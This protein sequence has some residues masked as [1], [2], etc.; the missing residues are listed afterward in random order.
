MLLH[1]NG[2]IRT[3]CDCVRHTDVLRA[4]S[5]TC[6]YSPILRFN[7]SNRVADAE[8]QIGRQARSGSL[9]PVYD[10]IFTS[11]WAMIGS[12]NR[13]LLR[14]STREDSATVHCDWRQI[15]ENSGNK[16]LYLMP[17]KI[18]N[19]SADVRIYLRA[20]L[21]LKVSRDATFVLAR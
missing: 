1:G 9:G 7:V 20:L 4:R 10:G 2:G 8:Y 3:I 16:T 13:L 18:W 15:P 21:K 5:L 17:D 14:K 11:D 19:R 6:G 12:I